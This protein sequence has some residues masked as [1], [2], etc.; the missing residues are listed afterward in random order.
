MRKLHESR[1]KVH[2]DLEP[3]GEGLR[4][5]QVRSVLPPATHPHPESASHTRA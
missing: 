3:E 2:L 4:G 1:Q 5:A